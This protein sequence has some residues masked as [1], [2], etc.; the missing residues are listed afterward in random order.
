[1]RIGN[2]HVWIVATIVGAGVATPVLPEESSPKVLF[3]T[4]DDD[5]SRYRADTAA[6]SISAFALLG[7]ATDHITNVENVRDVT[8]A[9]KGFGTK[10][11]GIGVSVTPARTS[12]DPIS[13]NLSTY[14][15]NGKR[16]SLYRLLGST[17]LGYARG[18]T[19]ISGVDFNRQA[20]SIQTNY[21]FFP[22][23][24]P[25]I[26][27]TDKLNTPACKFGAAKP[28][29]TP[30]EQAKEDAAEK[31]KKDNCAKQALDELRWNRSQVSLSYAT[32][33]IEPE[34]GSQGNQALGR[35]LALGLTYGF[36]GVGGPLEKNAAMYLTLRRSMDEPV[37]ET[38][39]T[40]SVERKDSNL[41]V[42]RLTGGSSQLRGLVEVSNANASQVTP[43]QRAFKRALG[44]DYRLAEGTWLAFRL[45]KQQ[46]FDGTKTATTSMLNLSYSPT[47]LLK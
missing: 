5:W 6:G 33:W 4:K 18:T 19:Q 32:G 10:D 28:G 39:A 1:M 30:E 45:G 29:L 36:E 22:A 24:D 21:F 3:G 42:L 9:L 31:A 13:M 38:L 23:D 14:Y 46:T 35:T 7:V 27:V 16:F 44:I 43:T 8:V 20:V 34:S 25:V 11:N 37:L 15:D 12:I 17:A 26:A 2:P 40:A 41:A 47:G